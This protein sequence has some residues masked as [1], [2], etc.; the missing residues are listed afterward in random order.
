MDV[1]SVIDTAV[2]LLTEVG[3]AVKYEGFGASTNTP[4]FQ[5]DA[6]RFLGKERLRKNPEVRSAV[7][8]HPVKMTSFAAVVAQ[9]DSIRSAPYV[10]LPQS[11]L[12]RRRRELRFGCMGRCRDESTSR[13]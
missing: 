2:V 8:A 13:R 3:V 11:R 9:W 4:G 5:K 10:S 1:D 7:L 6:R 12:R